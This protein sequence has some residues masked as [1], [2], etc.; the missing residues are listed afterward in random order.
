MI[1]GTAAKQVDPIHGGG[2]A[3]AMESGVLAA[4]AAIE[5]HKK[6]DFSKSVLYPYEKEWRSDRGS[7][8]RLAKRLMLR[9]VMEKASDDDINH[10]FNCMSATDLEDLMHGKFAGLVTKVLTGRPQLLG[11]LRGLL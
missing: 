1:I 2:I 4:H 8:P 9:K 3:I 7:G 5:A 11:V 6:K 10:I